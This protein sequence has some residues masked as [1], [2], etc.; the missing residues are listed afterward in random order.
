MVSLFAEKLTGRLQ[1]PEMF[2][3][4]CGALGMFILWRRELKFE[5][6]REVATKSP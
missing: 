1:V 5:E 6:R 2:T 4:I 3:G